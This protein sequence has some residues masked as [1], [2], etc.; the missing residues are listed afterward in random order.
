[1]IK[2]QDQSDLAAYTYTYTYTYTYSYTYTYTYTHTASFPHIL[3]HFVLAL[4]FCPNGIGNT[5]N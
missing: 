1:M 2:N 5:F 3:V 4:G